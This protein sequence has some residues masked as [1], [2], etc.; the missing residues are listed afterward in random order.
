MNG[1]TFIFVLFVFATTVIL[2]WLAQRQRASAMRHRRRVPEAFRDHISLGVHQ[3]AAD[4]TAAKM[5][6]DQIDNLLGA[7]LVLV[8]TL[9]GGL[10]F[11]AG[12]WAN[13]GWG[14]VAAGTGLMVSVFLIMALFD[15]PL[16]AY[17]TFIIEAKFGFNRTSLRLYLIDTLKQGVLLALLGTPL[18]ALL[19]WLVAHA[20]KWWW[21]NGWLIW[22]VFTAGMLWL[23]PTVI[24]PLFNRFTPLQDEALR[25][26][27]VRLLQHSG[28]TSGG[29]F[30]MDGSKRSRHGNAYFTGFGTNKRIVFFDTLLKGLKVD[31][32]EA[33]LAHELGHFKHGH[34]RKRLLFMA[35]TSLV[36][37]VLLGILI[38]ADWFYA[39]LGLRHVSS[40]GAFLLFLM[41]APYFTAPL[42]PLS[43]YWMRKHEFEAD[44][45]AAATTGAQNLVHALVKLYQ[46][47]AATLTP[48]ALYSAYH[49]SHPPAPIRIAHLTAKLSAP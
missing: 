9:G 24:A 12:L 32:V 39:G 19:L 13:S 47:N 27:I 15:I 14:D 23:Y 6:L 4:Y 41:A 44:D 11:L 37:F 34:I 49:D 46:E 26:R 38:G 43:S 28:F 21:L 25:A 1:F 5:R 2:L 17:R 18:I 31:E 45:F 16:D 48:D 36:A 35:A 33:V 10:N 29:I 22:M 20:G 30:V 8:W 3:K 42:R 40:A 7:L